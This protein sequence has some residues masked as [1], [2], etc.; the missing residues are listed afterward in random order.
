MVI[1]ERRLYEELLKIS[2][3]GK[4]AEAIKEWE[5]TGTYFIEPDEEPETCL[6]GHYPIYECCTITNKKTGKE[7]IVGNCCINRF[8]ETE[9]DLIFQALKRVKEDNTKSFN[10]AAIEYVYGKHII[11][12]WEYD[13]YK[14][15]MRKR[16]LSPKQ[17]SK[18]LSI[19]AKIL[20][21]LRKNTES[22][23]AVNQDQGLFNF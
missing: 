11:N 10:I 8:L 20:S 9:S 15:I 4:I 14:S 7:V 5:W 23:K 3:S 6:C 12:E 19:N 22:R 17:R 13:F 2:I 21:S 16:K 1:G 18:K